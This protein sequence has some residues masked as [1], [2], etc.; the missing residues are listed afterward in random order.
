MQLSTYLNQNVIEF[1]GMYMVMPREDD[2]PIEGDW[3]DEEDEDFDDQ[4]EGLDDLDELYEEAEYDEIDPDD[5]DHL[6]EEELQ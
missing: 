5:D 2:D 6:P 3:A 4:T 1:N